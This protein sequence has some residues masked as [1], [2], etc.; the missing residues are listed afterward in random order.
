LRVE[1]FRFGAA[2]RACTPRQSVWGFGFRIWASTLGNE[3]KE[4]TVRNFVSL[5]DETWWKF[6]FDWRTSDLNMR[7]EFITVDCVDPIELSLFVV[8]SCRFRCL[9]VRVDENEPIQSTMHESLK[10]MKSQVSRGGG[11]RCDTSCASST[12]LSILLL[13]LPAIFNFFAT[14]RVLDTCRSG[15]QA[16]F[17]VLVRRCQVI[18]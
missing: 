15:V 13:P 18:P 5:E 16:H 11:G 14:D 1:S 12:M 17:A 10:R 7:R 9:A 4:A 6:A 8:P 2:K 3:A